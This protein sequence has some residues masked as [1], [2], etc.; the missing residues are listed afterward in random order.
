MI[1]RPFLVL[2]LRSA[3]DPFDERENSYAM[4][5]GQDEANAAAATDAVDVAAPNAGIAANL[6]GIERLDPSSGFL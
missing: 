5:R 3:G 2:K 1:R 6:S 4:F